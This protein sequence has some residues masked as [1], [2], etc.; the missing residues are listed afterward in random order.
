MG[1]EGAG[2]RAPSRSKSSRSATTTRRRSRGARRPRL[3]RSAAILTLVAAALVLVGGQLGAW[4]AILEPIQVADRAPAPS[5]PARTPGPDGFG[6]VVWSSGQDLE[7]RGEQVRREGRPIPPA[8]LTGYE[9]PLPGAVLTNPY[10]PSQTGPFTVDGERFHD[11]IDLS[12]VCGDPIVAAHSGTVLAAGRRYDDTIGW[13]G[14]VAP[15]FE[16]LDRDKAWK[17]VAIA[18]VIDDG[19]GYRSIYAHFKSVVVTVGQRVEAGDPLGYEGKTGDATGCHLHYAIFSPRET[20]SIRL[21]RRVAERSLLPG[22]AIARIDPLLVLPPLE[23]GEI[24]LAD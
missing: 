8:E 7:E 21:I 11:G 20:A 16:R 24:T 6:P 12:T 23:A 3:A 19:N 9:W 22:R 17:G 5:G 10:G 15:Y 1:P 14:D 18:V 2:R 4:D 13:L